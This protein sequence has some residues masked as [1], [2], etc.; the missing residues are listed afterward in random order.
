MRILSVLLITLLASSGAF[1]R[2]DGPELLSKKELFEKTE[3]FEPQ[4]VFA[5]RQANIRLLKD[6]EANKA[7]YKPSQLLPVAVCY[8]T[9]NALPQSKETFEAFLKACPDNKRALRSLGTISLLTKDVDGAVSYYKRS[10]AAGDEHSNIFLG[11]AY[12]MS[13]KYGEISSILPVLKKLAKENLEAFNVVMLYAMR[14]SENKDGALMKETVE[15]ADAKKLLESASPDGMATTLRIYL[16]DR[17]IW[18]PSMLIVPARAAALTKVWIV[19]RQCYREVLK[20]EPDN[21]LALRGMGLVEYRTGDVSSASN[22]IKRAYDNGDK[23]A[24][25]DGLELFLLSNRRDLWDVYS[26]LVDKENLSPQLR[27]GLVQYAVSHEGNPDI[28]FT[29]ALGKGSDLLYKD[30]GVLKLLKE[31]VEK[32]S[33]DARSKT[34]GELVGKGESSLKADDG[35]DKASAK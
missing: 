32:Y 28:F 7:S 15:S 23:D 25:V 2:D 26:P 16:A 21:V 6:Y 3:L 31:G 18:T 9:V 14:D 30:K 11:S 19:S 27:A 24:A 33:S 1:A 8:L 10:V 35:A 22:F 17:K 4:S 13:G 34:V 12:L 29:G 20:A 5:D